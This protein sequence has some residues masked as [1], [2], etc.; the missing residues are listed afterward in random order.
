MKKRRSPITL[1][2]VKSSK[3]AM[4]AVIEI[5]NK[6]QISYRYEIVVLLLINAWELLL[7]AYIYRNLKNVKLFNND[8][9]T[10]PFPDC[11]AC[12]FSNLGND[13]L[14]VKENIEL[15]YEYRNKIAHF[16]TGILDPIIFMLVKK[17]VIFFA[18]FLNHFFKIDIADNSNLYLLPIGFK[19]I[20]T[21]VDYLS[22]HSVAEQ[23]P[24]LIRSFID[25][26]LQVSETLHGAGIEESIISDFNMSLVNVKRIKNADII[27]ATTKKP[28][29]DS[30]SIEIYKN[31]NIVDADE[32]HQSKI[33]ITR[34]KSKSYGVL[35]HEELSEN[36]FE[37]INNLISANRL[38]SPN[39]DQFHLGEEVYSRI[40]AER[41]HVDQNEEIQLLLA[42]TA[43]TKYYAPGIYWFLNL[44][45]TICASLILEFA[46]SMKN[47]YVH[48]FL[49]LVIL[50][51]ENVASWLEAI[52]NERYKN[53]TQPPTYYWT[54]KEMRKKKDV[55]E[56]RLLALRISVNQRLDLPGDQKATMVKDLLNNTD[57]ASQYLSKACINVFK[58]KKEDRNI[59]RIL[60][61]L[62]YGKLL[63][64]KADHIVQAI[65]ENR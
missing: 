27:V 59:S 38:M 54:Y 13:Y 37:E 40:Y 7:K 17:S 8:G 24:S 61:I 10:K 26:I 42:K 29:K 39:S 65:K 4:L 34:D 31:V 14:P 15:L 35:M 58:G 57:L 60:D 33:V 49:R 41:E 43:L 30:R 22:K 23:H 55:R 21:P 12:V 50:L 62:V 36:L 53:Y 47:P 16:Y 11:V 9:T 52:L 20:Y 6:P 1:S 2:L 46:E 51:G 45:A 3:S 44:D 32:S 25:K 48:S 5:H 19:P 63:E 56:R 64:D 28:E 18:R